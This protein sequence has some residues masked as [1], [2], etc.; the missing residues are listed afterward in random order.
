MRG[1]RKAEITFSFFRMFPFVSQS[2]KRPMISKDILKR[3]LS[4]SGWLW[5][6]W[7]SI[8]Q[9][10]EKFPLEANAWR[11][12]IIQ[13]E[14]ILGI[15]KEFTLFWQLKRLPYK[16]RLKARQWWV[17]DRQVYTFTGT[18]WIF[19]CIDF[20]LNTNATSRPKDFVGQITGYLFISLPLFQIWP[21]WKKFFFL[22]ISS[23]ILS[24]LILTYLGPM[25]GP[26]L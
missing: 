24:P 15:K 8:S 5:N 10:N 1:E 20:C 25:S 6:S 7:K 9:R 21:H 11:R 17:N 13:S 16:V 14:K 18:I 19:N 12:K 3:H 22:L 2:P 23:L 4:F 26:N